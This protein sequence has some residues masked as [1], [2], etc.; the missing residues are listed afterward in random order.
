MPYWPM[1]YA[2]APNAP[3]GATRMI[4]RMMVKITVRPASIT[5]SSGL[6]FSWPTATTA[7]PANTENTS[8]CRMLL[9]ASA[10]KIL[11]GRALR[12]KAEKEV[13]ALAP[14]VLASSAEA[15][16]VDGSMFNPAPG[17]T[18]LPVIMPN[19]MAKVETARKYSNALPPTR[20]TAL[21]SPMHAMPVMTTSRISGEITILIS[22]MNASPS[23]FT[24]AAKPGQSMPTTTPATIATTSWKNS[25]PATVLGVRESVPCARA[26]RCPPE[27]LRGPPVAAMDTF[28]REAVGAVD[29][30]MIMVPS[31][32]KTTGETNDG[33]KRWR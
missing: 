32:W 21:M 7:R 1:M 13:V 28:G 6:T 9:L 27:C 16:S 12:M 14:F 19:T 15:S 8:T 17:R 33:D 25:E 11:D 31:I 3:R 26:G 5:S 10:S 24:C 29:A 18:R 4:Q 30:V 2:I 20:P 22:T 23:S